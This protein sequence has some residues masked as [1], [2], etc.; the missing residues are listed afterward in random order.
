MGSKLL[1]FAAPPRDGAVTPVVYGQTV[2]SA[3]SDFG[4]DVPDP[5]GYMTGDGYQ[6]V[7]GTINELADKAGDGR[8]CDDIEY[9]LFQYP[10][11]CRRQES[12]K[13]RG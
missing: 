1:Y 12:L 11:W 8:R 4:F 9:A 2:V 3:P 13:R 10:T 6:Y 7:C 5:A